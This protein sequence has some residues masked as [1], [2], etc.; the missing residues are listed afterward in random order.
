MT[1][2]FWLWLWCLLLE[3]SS[4]CCPLSSARQIFTAV[5]LINNTDR[6]KPKDKRTSIFFFFV[7]IQGCFRVTSSTCL[8]IIKKRVQRGQLKVKEEAGFS[9][10]GIKTTYC[11]E[12][13]QHYKAKCFNYHPFIIHDD[14][15]SANT[16]FYHCYGIHCELNA[17]AVHSILNERVFGGIVCL[18][19]VLQFCFGLFFFKYEATLDLN[20]FQIKC[21]VFGDFQIIQSYS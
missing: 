1:W 9:P 13:R 17:C 2:I 20:H 16:I 3:L 15:H 14:S 21:V 19:I 12:S 7:E 8:A 18:L 10:Y 5:G 11:N 4:S 6:L